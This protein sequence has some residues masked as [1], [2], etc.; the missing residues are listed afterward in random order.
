MAEST[1]SKPWL[2]TLIIFVAGI[3]LT[4]L[5][6]YFIGTVFSKII[7]SIDKTLL[8]AGLIMFVI[9]IVLLW[10]QLSRFFKK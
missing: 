10:I 9:G 7:A 8:I 5:G 6:G 2:N 1:G 4:I 3:A